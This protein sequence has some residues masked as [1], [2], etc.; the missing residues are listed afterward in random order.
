MH[1]ISFIPLWREVFT[2]GAI[3]PA[4]K[5]ACQGTL[6]EQPLEA[7]RFGCGAVMAEHFKLSV[8]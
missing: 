4:F 7:L 8:S 3:V 1:K 6:K 5:I 2:D